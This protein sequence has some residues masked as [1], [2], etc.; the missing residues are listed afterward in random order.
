MKSFR[1][2]LHI[3]TVLSPCGDLDMSPVQI[4]DLIRLQ[5]INIVA[6]T[7]H[8]ATHHGPLVRRL[9]EPYGIKVFFGAEVTSKEEAH[10]LCLFEEEEQRVAFQEFIDLN[11]PQIPNKPE[12]FGYQVVVNEAED[13][14]QEIEYLL[15]SAL[16]V[17]VNQIEHEVHRLG[18]LFIPAHVDKPRYSLTSQLGFIPSDLNFDALELSRNTSTEVFL[19][20]NR[21]LKQQRFVRN[22]DAHYLSDIGK[23]TTSFNI[24]EPTLS[25]MKMALWGVNGR[26][27]EL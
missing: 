8:N 2:D 26:S 14:L 20:S 15:I 24:E 5:N 12:K 16:A 11:L 22:S 13:I 6:I 9:A 3:H 17:G 4:V 21:Y 10:L 18:G 19:A 1:A 25:E 23:Q 27:V 7:D